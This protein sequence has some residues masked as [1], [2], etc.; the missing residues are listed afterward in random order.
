MINSL[1]NPAIMVVLGAE[2]KQERNLWF[3]QFYF[4]K[5]IDLYFKK[6]LN[7]ITRQ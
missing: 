4:E 7:A 1:F 3:L 5:E 6:F 2:K